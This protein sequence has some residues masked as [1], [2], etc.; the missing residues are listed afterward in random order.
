MAQIVHIR[1]FQNFISPGRE[2]LKKVLWPPV[3]ILK[4]HVQKIAGNY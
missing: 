1:S 2:Y 4:C 3:Q